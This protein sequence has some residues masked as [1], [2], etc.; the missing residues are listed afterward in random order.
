MKTKRKRCKHCKTLFVPNNGFHVTCTLICAIRWAKT[1][2][3]TKHR[4]K[5]VRASDKARLYQLNEIK[6]R[7]AAARKSCH[8]YIRERD[9]HNGCITCSNPLGEKFDAGHFLKGTNSYTMFMEKN[10]SGQCVNCNQFNGGRE[11]EYEHALIEKYGLITVLALK[12]LRTRTI[13]RTADDY[14]AIERHYKDKLKGLND[15]S[16]EVRQKI[17]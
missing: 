17:I 16:T 7:K 14:S 11:R 9:K 8:A 15:G 2:A 5:A 12:R 10:I 6:I 1:K 4:E 3:A 13:K